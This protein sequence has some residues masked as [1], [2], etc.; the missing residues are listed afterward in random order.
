MNSH[1]LFGCGNIQYEVIFVKKLI[2]VL[3]YVLVAALAA[4]VTLS[5]T[6]RNT[7]TVTVQ[8]SKLSQLQNLIEQCFI[9]EVDSTAIED[10]A[11]NA[12]V[13]AL[14]DRWSYYISAAEYGSYKE[15]MAN[16]YVGI[17]ITIQLKGENE[18]FLITQVNPNGPAYEAGILAGDVIVGV[19]GT[20]VR[21]MIMDDVAAMVKGEEG[22]FVSITVER[23]GAPLTFT[24]ER[25]TVLITVATGVMLEGN[26]GLVTIANFDSRCAEETIAIIDSL[27]E[28]G[29]EALI[30]D[31]RNNPGGYARELVK[32]L[33]H[34]LPECEVF[35]TVDYAG[36]ED[37]DYSDENCIDPI[38][39][40]VLVNSESYSAA[41]FFAAALRDYEMAVIVGE[42]TCGKG[43]FQYTYPLNDGSAVGLSVGEYFTPSGEN[44]AGVGLTP[45]YPV[46]VDDETFMKIY[47]G[48]LDPMEDPQ[49]LKALEVLK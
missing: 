43:Y 12:M 39:M 22:T 47:A 5:V 23:E 19:E 27:L 36:T 35:R 10:A 18:G 41:E 33:D 9:G 26:V 40:V 8:Q 42:K 20:D 4:V 13:D 29:A 2:R 30:F 14:G 16:A 44:L 15:Q 11:A 17:G 37:V 7:P 1:S 31:V 48:T 49:I 6:W 32:V 46:D 45:D 38:P 25:R 3:S 24:V 21:E 34:L 28:E